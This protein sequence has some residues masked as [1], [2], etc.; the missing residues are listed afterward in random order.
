MPQPR[1]KLRFTL[2]VSMRPV[3]KRRAPSFPKAPFIFDGDKPNSVGLITQAGTI[4]YLTRIASNAWQTMS[5]SHRPPP[6]FTLMRPY[7]RINP[8]KF[9]VCGPAALPLFSLAPHGVFRASQITPRAVSSYLAFSTLP[10]LV[11]KEPAV[12][13]L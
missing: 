9:G 7:P 13:F 10:S 3:N 8:E 11:A 6:Q 1:S 2:A 4:I 12:C 5:G